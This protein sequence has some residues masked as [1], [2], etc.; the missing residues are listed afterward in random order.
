MHLSQEELHSILNKQSVSSAAL[1]GA[2]SREL[3]R[4][5]E[6]KASTGGLTQPGRATRR[7]EQAA[8]DR[9]DKILKRERLRLAQLEVEQD[10]AATLQRLW[11][12]HRT[13]T[14]VLPAMRM[15]MKL[16]SQW[17]LRSIFETI[18]QM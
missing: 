9:V 2:A 12:G 11:R 10:A 13:R 14:R 4:T 1:P 15:Q 18:V 8:S 5:L 6:R 16:M 3:R 17:N 7:D